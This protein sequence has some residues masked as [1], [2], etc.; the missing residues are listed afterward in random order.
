MTLCAHRYHVQHSI[1]SNH[2]WCGICHTIDLFV[3]INSLLDLK[4]LQWPFQ[5]LTASNLVAIINPQTTR[6]EA[7]R[8]INSKC[9]IRCFHVVW[10]SAG[11]HLSSKHCCDDYL[12]P[13]ISFYDG[14]SIVYLYHYLLS[15]WSL[16]SLYFKY[17][18]GYVSWIIACIPSMIIARNNYRI[19]LL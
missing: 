3:N 4:R 2:K 14:T 5:L 7:W 18:I 12:P 13:L 1:A 11:L 8:V 15:S 19:F 6:T 16:A 17:S 10:N 9:L